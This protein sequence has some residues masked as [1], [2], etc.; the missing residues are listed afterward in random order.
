MAY[1][2]ENGLLEASPDNAAALIQCL[3]VKR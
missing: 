2:I 3:N 1:Q